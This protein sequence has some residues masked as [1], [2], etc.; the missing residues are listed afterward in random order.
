MPWR[1]TAQGRGSS[2]SFALAAAH[3]AG[4]LAKRRRQGHTSAPTVFHVLGD[5]VDGLLGDDGE[6]ADQAGMLQVLHHVGLS[7][8][9]LH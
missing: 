7:Q 4:L 8:E 5:D 3:L 6:E 2:F 1:G 9:G